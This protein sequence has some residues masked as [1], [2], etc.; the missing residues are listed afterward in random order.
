MVEVELDRF[1]EA[2]GVKYPY[3]IGSWLNNWEV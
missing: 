1:E 3:A 2:C